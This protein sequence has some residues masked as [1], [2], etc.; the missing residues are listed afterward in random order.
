MTCTHTVD[1]LKSGS[2]FVPSVPI[3]ALYNS[4]IALWI[5]H[6]GCPFGE[7][8]GKGDIGMTGRPWY[9]AITIRA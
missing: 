2:G 7:G 8:G 3:G 4:L 5:P 6:I 9:N 1:F